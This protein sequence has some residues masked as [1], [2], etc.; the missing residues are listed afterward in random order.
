MFLFNQFFC[1]IYSFY[2]QKKNSDPRFTAVCFLIII[3]IFILAL[4][5]M[6][7]QNI[8][9][10]GLIDSKDKIS[11]FYFIPLGIAWLYLV[12]KYYNNDR[13]KYLIE[14]YEKQS[15]S[16]KRVWELL[17]LIFIIG[18]VIVMFFFLLI[19]KNRQELCVC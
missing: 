9:H 4:P 7:L 5:I 15:N 2:L 17:S 11:K 13:I 19:I 10:I 6:I 16:Y 8:Y 3:Q 12:N 1:S 18:P 14:A